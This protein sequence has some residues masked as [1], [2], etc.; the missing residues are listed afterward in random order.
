MKTIFNLIINISK[1]T[2][3]SPFIV[4]MILLWIQFGVWW[5]ITEKD[6]INPEFSTMH[7]Y[8][9][10]GETIIAGLLL[11][12]KLPGWAKKNPSKW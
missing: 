3:L 6:K 2:G 9:L 8:I 12:F 10:I 7:L 4:S 11:W 1:K 5:Y